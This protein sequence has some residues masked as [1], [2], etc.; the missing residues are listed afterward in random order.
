LEKTP[1]FARITEVLDLKGL[2]K[3]MN[4]ARHKKGLT[5]SGRE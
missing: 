3:E 4:K 2:K 1:Y 5:H